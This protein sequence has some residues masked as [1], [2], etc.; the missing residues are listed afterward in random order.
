MRRLILLAFICQASIG[1]AQIQDFQYLGEDYWDHELYLGAAVRHVS[2]EVPN[3]P[4]PSAH[5]ASAWTAD[6]QLYRTAPSIPGKMRYML[7]NK[8]LGEIFLGFGESF[9]DIYRDEGSTFSHFFIGANSFAWNLLGHDRLQLAVGFNLT[10]LVTGSTFVLQDSLG[11]D[12][13]ET[14]APHGWYIGSGPSLFVDFLINKYLLLELQYDYTFH[15]TN[16]VPLTYGVED[17]NQKMPHQ[18]FLSMNLMTSFGF[19][20]GIDY[21][22]LLDQNLAAMNH[23]KLDWIIGFKIML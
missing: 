2:I 14:P 4:N 20:T 5:K 13:R 22:L 11:N 10:D 18:S 15:F 21:S 12:Y 3:A 8:I 16:P 19:Y 17:P 9:R 23:R 6:F 7:R 1:L